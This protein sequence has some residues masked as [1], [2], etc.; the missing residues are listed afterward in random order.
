M[1]I[2]TGR[3]KNSQ[4]RKKGKRSDGKTDVLRL[5]APDRTGV[6][7]YWAFYFNKTFFY[8]I[9]NIM[10][11]SSEKITSR[12]PADFLAFFRCMEY[13]ADFV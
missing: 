10:N 4:L 11:N 12:L 2:W 5:S 6:G 3:A 1:I 9:P 13:I 8:L 7:P